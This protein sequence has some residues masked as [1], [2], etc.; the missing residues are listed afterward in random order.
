RSFSLL[1]GVGALCFLTYNLIRMPVL[2]LFADSLGAGPEAIGF[3]VAASTL[4][5]VV[6]K[7][8]S[9]LLSDMYGRRLL[10][11]I[12]IVMFAVPPFAYLLVSNVGSLTGLRFIHGMATAIFAPAA[13]AAVADL[14]RERRGTTLGIYT[15]STQAGALFG[16][17]LGGWLV[18][19]VG[20]P[21]TFVA[22]GL[23]GGIA[24]L[25]F[26]GLRLDSGQGLKKPPSVKPVM[27]EMRDRVGEAARNIPVITTSI[28]DA[29]K[30]VARG[31]LMAFLPIY[32]ISVGLN[33]GEVGMLFGVQ[34]VTSLLAKPAMGR[35]SDH[36][37]RRPLILLGLLVCAATFAMIPHV[38]TFL[39]LA[40][41][42]A[43]FGFG[44]AIV[45]ASAAA[46]VADLSQQKGLGGGMGLQ[47]TIMDLGHASGPLIAGF[48][49]ASVSFRGA[50]M[51][52]AGLQILVAAIFWLTTR[53]GRI[54][55]H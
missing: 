2:A 30:M 49:I 3:V 26:A 42:A 24:L 54:R 29:A 33:P 53:S 25:L 35:V 46:L 4:T 31:A 36:V 16:P 41:F 9:G 52:I 51:V 34:G 23:I 40:S 44:E 48:L 12:G 32:G 19:A 6:L 8:P 28:A 39:A 11:G 14:Y 50:F 37:G 18:Y 22:G 7:L 20:F 55:A 43:G 1:C 10:L 38:E 47:G 21:P 13:L 45:T 17:V 5:G 27:T 15:A